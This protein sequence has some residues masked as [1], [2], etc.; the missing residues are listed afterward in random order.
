MKKTIKINYMDF[1][2]YS[3]PEKEFF[4][5]FLRQ[6]YNVVI[7]DK[8]DYIFYTLGGNT[9]HN[10]PG[11]RIFWTGENVVPN[12]N[13]SDYALGFQHMTFEDRYHRLPLWR[14]CLPDLKK[15]L[16]K[17]IGRS[18]EELLQRG[19]CATVISNA[20]QTDG[21]REEAFTKLSAYKPV[22]S[23]GRWQNNV[24]GP[25]KDKITFQSQYKFALAFE[26]TYA[27]GYTTEKILQAFASD[28]VPIYYGDPRVSEDFNPDAFIN[29]HDFQT[30]DQLVDFV[31]KV[32]RDDA[33]YLKMM[34]VPVF[35]NGKLPDDLTDEALLRF[36]EPI[37]DAPLEQARRRFF[38]KPYQDIDYENLKMR[39]V[40]AMIKAFCYK[41]IKRLNLFSKRK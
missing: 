11:I 14:M 27:P 13:Y 6:K 36:F 16:Q 20:R 25:I 40:K 3:D 37:F 21:R 7:S 29:A 1:G 41:Q 15:A 17:S 9:H 32:D 5:P 28:C 35:K 34:R 24:G 38:A 30:I 19:F 12:F 23:G 39:D 33:L 22:A 8:P 26:N 18:D 2:R 31:Q 4:T 10:F